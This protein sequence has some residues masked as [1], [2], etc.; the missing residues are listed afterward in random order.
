MP[1]V[2]AEKSFGRWDKFAKQEI[3]DSDSLRQVA[4]IRVTLIGK[5]NKVGITSLTQLAT[6]NETSCVG[7]GTSIFTK[8]K[9]QAS[10]QL[11]SK[12]T[13]LP[14]IEFLEEIDGKGFK[15]LPPHHKADVFFDIE[16]HPLVEGGS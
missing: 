1:D 5:L 8:L 2:S 14:L 11:A 12:S 9:T 13:E 7:I 4:G 10:L 15:K 16:G 6:T 3:E